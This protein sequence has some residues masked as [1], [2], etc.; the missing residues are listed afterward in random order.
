MFSTSICFHA[1]IGINTQNP[2]GSFH[3]DG[4]K[5][6][7]SAGTPATSQTVNDLVVASS[8]NLG[9]GNINPTT[10]L[11]ITS[12]T[13]NTSGLKMTNLT[14]VTPIS[15]GQLLGVDSNGNIIT[16]ANPAPTN[17]Q[18]FEVNS[19]ASNTFS[20][21]DAAWT[22]VTGTQQTVTIPAGGKALFINF[23]LGLRYSSLASGAAAGYYTARLFIDGVET[24][25][26]QTAQESGVPAQFNL[27]S[28]K[29]LSAGNHTIDV[30]MRRTANISVTPNSP[31]GTTTLSINFNASYLN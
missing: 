9:I 23:I 15:T 11:E 26:Y 4:A 18:A 6:N 16:I 27:S 12:A 1:Q 21:S 29:F 25:V 8:G 5:D 17:I 31:Q 20:V 28:V 24:R 7:P 13:A 14:S 3:I 30:R 2:Q 19:S 22:I 10:K